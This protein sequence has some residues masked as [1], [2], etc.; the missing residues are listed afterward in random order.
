[1]LGDSYIK[2]IYYL[3]IHQDHETIVVC[4]DHEINMLSQ[5]VRRIWILKVL[6]L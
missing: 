2:Y 1:M 3:Y 5:V 4:H 6:W